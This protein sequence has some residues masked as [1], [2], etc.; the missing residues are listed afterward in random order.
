MHIRAENERRR[1]TLKVKVPGRMHMN[2]AAS[3]LQV[4]NQEGEKVPPQNSDN[5]NSQSRSTRSII[6]IMFSPKLDSWLRRGYL[7]SYF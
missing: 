7:T 6:T 3:S 2:G 1:V 4:L 5:E